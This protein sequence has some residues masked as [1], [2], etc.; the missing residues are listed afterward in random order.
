MTDKVISFGASEGFGAFAGWEAQSMSKP[1]STKRAVALD[2]VGNEVADNTFDTRTDITCTY[3]CVNDTNTIPDTIGAIINGYVLTGISIQ[4]TAED[5]A[6][7]TLTGHNHAENAHFSLQCV[8]HGITLAKCFGCTDFSGDSAGTNDSPIS[9]SCDITIEHADQND[10]EGNHL[11][12]ENYHAKVEI[13]TTYAGDHT[14][15][16]TGYDITV[17]SET[18][19]NTGFT[20]T[21]VTGQKALGALG[22]PA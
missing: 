21:E 9:S 2:D 7:M 17:D 5:F 15:V 11:V 1:T 20:K 16:F 13:K 14:P 6:T 18:D 12:G 4:T 8:A 10:F 22:A 19:E 3:K